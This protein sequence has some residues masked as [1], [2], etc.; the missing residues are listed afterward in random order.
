MEISKALLDTLL[1]GAANLHP[2]MPVRPFPRPARRARAVS[3]AIGRFDRT[4]HHTG[5]VEPGTAAAPTASVVAMATDASHATAPLPAPPAPPAGK[6]RARGRSDDPGPSSSVDSMD[7]D[8]DHRG[9][10]SQEAPKKRRS[11]IACDAPPG[12][13]QVARARAAA[14]PPDVAHRCARARPHAR[15]TCRRLR[16]GA[17]CC[18]CFCCTGR[19]LHVGRAAAHGAG[20]AV[21]CRPLRPPRACARAR[22]TGLRPGYGCSP[23]MTR[24]LTMPSVLTALRRKA[25]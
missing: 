7:H 1:A 24:W 14:L 21:V 18:R 4:P 9:G 15:T 2:Q 19:A 5:A 13:A 25:R 8:D 11:S 22:S 16:C 6:P 12:A 20:L 23:A 17:G 10:V 3:A